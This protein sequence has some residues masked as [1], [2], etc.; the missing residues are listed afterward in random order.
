M[1]KVPALILVCLLV[2]ALTTAGSVFADATTK[3]LSTNYTVQNL[4]DA[5]ANVVASYMK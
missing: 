2:A 5:T 4:G 3:N 1:K